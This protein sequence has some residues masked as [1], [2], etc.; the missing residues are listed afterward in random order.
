MEV[1]ISHV[2]Q[3]NEPTY[4]DFTKVYVRKVDKVR[5]I[6]GNTTAHIDLDNSFL[7]EVEI[8]KKQ[9]GEYRLMPFKVSK[10][11]LCDLHDEDKLFYPELCK[12]SDF[13]CPFKCPMP[14]G[15]Y[16]YRGFTPSLKN[17]PVSIINSGDYATE[18]TIEKDGKVYLS[19][20]IY[21]SLISF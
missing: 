9:G 12:A 2:E 6:F 5:K 3:L 16:A 15:T 17:T 11:G 13:K 1:D 10:K 21:V 4:I 7:C 18:T 19:F 8:Y 14:A 20:R